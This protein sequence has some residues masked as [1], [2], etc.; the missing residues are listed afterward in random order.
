MTGGKCSGKA[1]VGVGVFLICSVRWNWQSLFCG[2]CVRIT[3][4]DERHNW[5]KVVAFQRFSAWVKNIDKTKTITAMEK[6]CRHTGHPILESLVHKL[7]EDPKESLSITLKAQFWNK[8]ICLISGSCVRLYTSR[9]IIIA[10]H[11]NE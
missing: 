7:A 8:L 11:V 6:K 9:K 5:Y 1:I 2:Y 3:P 10:L 4:G